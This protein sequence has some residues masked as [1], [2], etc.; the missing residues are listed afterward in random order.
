MEHIVGLQLECSIVY[1]YRTYVDVVC[2]GVNGKSDQL[3][4]ANMPKSRSTGDLIAE[5]KAHSG[6]AALR[7]VGLRSTDCT[8]VKNR[9]DGGGGGG[10]M[11]RCQKHQ[12]MQAKISDDD[13]SRCRELKLVTL[14]H[15]NTTLP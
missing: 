10:L 7:K 6:P 11:S 3:R 14:R 9:D 8:P 12:E 1:R 2:T 15:V 13:E 4:A 5:L